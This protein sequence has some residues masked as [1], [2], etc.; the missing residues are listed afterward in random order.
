MA[1]VATSDRDAQMIGLGPRE[2]LITDA[3]QR[4]AAPGVLHAG[5]CKGWIQ[6]IAAVHEPRSGVHLVTKPERGVRVGRPDGR[7]QS[8]RAVVHERDRFGIVLHLHDA[9]DRT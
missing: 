6:V 1:M 5:P 2:L 4:T 9:D 3:R 8:E 7:R